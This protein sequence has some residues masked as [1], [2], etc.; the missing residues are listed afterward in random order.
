LVKVADE[1]VPEV[2]FTD[3]TIS[4]SLRDGRMIT[5]PLV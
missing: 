5:V 2:Q 4:V 3:D 1:R